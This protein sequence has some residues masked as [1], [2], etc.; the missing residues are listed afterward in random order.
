MSV[1]EPHA[2]HTAIDRGPDMVV[3]DSHAFKI[4]SEADK[5][6]RG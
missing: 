2:P 6:R 5:R 1:Q 3:V 4:V